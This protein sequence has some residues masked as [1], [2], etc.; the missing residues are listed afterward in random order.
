MRITV[1]RGDA[2]Y[3]DV[4]DAGRVYSPLLSMYSGRFFIR[5]VSMSTWRRFDIEATHKLTLHIAQSRLSTKWL[6]L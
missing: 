3:T 5:R 6:R 1:G 2:F 4:G